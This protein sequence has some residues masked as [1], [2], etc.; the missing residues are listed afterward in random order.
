MPTA[1]E[2]LE[3]L[4][5]QG[6][7][8]SRDQASLA[9][10]ILS[11]V[12]GDRTE[13][14]GN[15]S[16]RADDILSRVSSGA[17]GQSSQADDIL[18]RLST[19]IDATQPR[20]ASLMP[21]PASRVRQ[22]EQNLESTLLGSEVVDP[23]DIPSVSDTV[24][25]VEDQA[26]FLRQR[27]KRLSSSVRRK[28][29]R[30][31][32]SPQEIAAAQAGVQGALE[33]GIQAGEAGIAEQRAEE[34]RGLSFGLG[35]AASGVTFGL[36]DVAIKEIADATGTE[37][38]QAASGGEALLGG[39][40]NM[41][42]GILTGKAVF[43]KFGGGKGGL[44]RVLAV[45][46][47][48]GGATSAVRNAS[49]LWTG[50][51]DFATAARD[52]VIDTTLSAV[53]VV[54]EAALK[55]G[56]RNFIGQVGTGIVGDLLADTLITK[57]FQELGAKEWILQELP[58][59]AMDAVFAGADL[60]DKGFPARQKQL[61]A[62]L[63][64]AVRDGVNGVKSRFTRA[65]R[66][67]FQDN[68]QQGFID[69]ETG[70]PL[71]MAQL[72]RGVQAELKQ[73]PSVISELTPRPELD[74]APRGTLEDVG[75]AERERVGRAREDAASQREQQLLLGRSARLEAEPD[76]VP[77]K[78][79]ATAKPIEPEVEA[80]Q[81]A[82][83]TS[84]GVG[85]TP[86]RAVADTDPS[87]QGF[88]DS[89]DN[90]IKAADAEIKS[91][92]VGIK[93]ALT[94][95][96]V[97][98]SGAV[99]DALTDINAKDAV[100]MR[101]LVSGASSDAKH[102]HTRAMHHIYENLPKSDEK[103]MAQYIVA[104]RVVETSEIMRE[105]GTQDFEHPAGM[106]EQNARALVSEVESD[107][108]NAPIIE[109]SGRFW[110][111]MRTSL[112]E[113][114]DN[115]LLS[116]EAHASL[117]ENHRF[118]SPRQ[119]VKF[120]DEAVGSEG[121]RAK[122][123]SGVKELSTGDEGAMNTDP[124]SMIAQVKAR[125]ASRVF[126]NRANTALLE[127]ARTTPDNGV[128]RELGEGQKPKLGE[129]EVL[130]F[131]DGQQVRMA[132]PSKLAKEWNKTPPGMQR[133]VAEI[134]KYLTGVKFV[135]AGATSFNPTFFISNMPRDMAF[136]WFNSGEYS[137][138]L[139]KAIV[140]QLGDVGSVFGDA[141]QRKGLY[142]EYIR[143][144]GGMDFLSTE[145]KVKADPWKKTGRG[146]RQLAQVADVLTHLNETS[147]IVMRLAVMK[148]G[149]E[150]GLSPDEA[151]FNARRM[152]DFA[153]GGK[154]AKALDTA[155]PYLNAAIQGTRGT[156]RTFKSDPAEG[157]FKAAQLIAAG[158]AMS[159]TARAL[160]GDEYD[161]ISE[162][163]RAT[164]WILPL[165]FKQKDKNGNTRRAYI[166][167]AKDQGQQVFS[168]MGQASSDIMAGKPWGKSTINAMQSFIPVDLSG[169]ADVPVYA[170]LRA[171]FD[172]YDTWR[173]QKIWQGDPETS[174]NKERTLSTPSL[175]T[176]I[177]DA[178]SKIGIQVSP[179]R[180][181]AA[182][183]KVIPPQNPIVSIPNDIV[184]SLTGKVADDTVIE[185]T[186]RMPGIRRLL[187]WS[188]PLEVT[189]SQ[190]QKAE[191]FGVE[192]EGRTPLEIGRETSEL[193]R[194]RADMRADINLESDKIVNDIRVG[195]A[196]D[197]DLR[198]FILAQDSEEQV[199]LRRRI[200]RRNP[201]LGAK[202]KPPRRSTSRRR[203]SRSREKQ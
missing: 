8:D 50:D 120:I 94:R 28:Q 96:L 199:R 189:E 98:D 127:S 29:L 108:R 38:A 48:L 147:E 52:T 58:R 154:T 1:D 116:A 202:L 145:G 171:Y 158:F 62:E 131:E 115:G 129:S 67:N 105:R 136:S 183:G 99:K 109:A 148:R 90:N 31:T 150:R 7:N 111:E 138:F 51:K 72:L 168:A 151:V 167:I 70:Q 42:G 164:K 30:G 6:D 121:G 137:K 132:M 82:A 86:Q 172:N 155:V 198:Q 47:G 194:E 169:G 190:A 95:H 187:R 80:R 49:Q 180:L 177:S 89:F 157:T 63:R 107:P 76:V 117:T 74:K 104:K 77:V 41:L 143:R 141:F 149:M 161:S 37:R 36:S 203:P 71:D 114:K 201:E 186:R 91:Q 178:A 16:S 13:S 195:R 34:V 142:Q 45:R 46:A 193:A 181:T 88:R 14:E 92:R 60:R 133:D 57:R 44:K 185:L 59:I 140:Q 163:E 174:P 159:Q 179:E 170:A 27:S 12:A 103:A 122:L 200:S 78:T 153:Q 123:D 20:Y 75:T 65:G 130:A 197:N 43:S 66:N 135:K 146:K 3:R 68:R 182:T 100:I 25:R 134:V 81:G 113:L 10:D 192:T 2:I 118:Y 61:D 73:E 19:S 39:I 101:T 18:A 156:L 4:S 35:Q 56:M 55:P 110:D 32:A 97:D 173:N 22:G 175:S 87:A 152:L 102:E 69:S 33:A 106:T 79:E 124:R 15:L 176:G 166:A 93:E 162:R 84:G 144:G 9:D 160:M 184:D 53:S 24:G 119:F 40:T 64:K 83:E 5:L 23:S 21:P 26:E 191:R 54:P 165:P 139:P 128:I 112:D 125:T 188:R 196:T 11:R 85:V 126:K 17:D